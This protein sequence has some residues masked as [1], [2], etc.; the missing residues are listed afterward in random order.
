[1]SIKGDFLIIVELLRT[2]F[3]CVLLEVIVFPS[4]RQLIQIYN[5]LLSPFLEKM[6][7]GNKNIA[8]DSRQRM[9]FALYV[10]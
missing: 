8:I 5:A 9:F 2:N 6:M 7:I 4:F 3:L 10:Y 1:M